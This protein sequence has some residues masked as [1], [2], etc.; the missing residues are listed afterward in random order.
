MQLV[1]KM[2]LV[3]V[4]SGVLVGTLAGCGDKKEPEAPKKTDAPAP[5]A[6]KAK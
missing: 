6:P 3:F 1:K 4:A 5:E 2:A